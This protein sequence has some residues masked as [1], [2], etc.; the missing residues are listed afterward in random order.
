MAFADLVLDRLA[1]LDPDRI[2]ASRPGAAPGGG[3]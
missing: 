3:T 2:G 1:D